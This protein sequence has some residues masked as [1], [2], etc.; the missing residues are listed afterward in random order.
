MRIKT[1]TTVTG[2][3]EIDFGNDDSQITAH[4]Y[5]FKNLSDS[6]LYVSSKPNPIAGEDNVAELSAKGAASVETDEGKVYVLG[7]GKVEIHRTNSKFCPFELPSNSSG[8]GGSSI[9]VDSELSETSINPVENKAIAGA[10][11]DI[12]AYIETITNDIHRI[13]NPNLLTNPD[14]RINQ[15]GLSTETL[16]TS[17]RYFIDRWKGQDGTISINNNGGINWMWDGT[18]GSYSKIAQD[19]ENLQ[20]LFGK[21]V[22]VSMDIDSVRKSHTFTLPTEL[23]KM[24]DLGK[25]TDNIRVWLGINSI[26]RLYFAILNMSATAVNINNLKLE[27]GSNATPFIPPEYSAELLKCQRYYQIHSTNNISAVDM[28]P[29]M[30]DS[31]NPTITALSNGNY[32]YSTEL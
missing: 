26:G 31:V 9:T 18:N 20:A 32:S 12:N 3:N 29:N 15:Y 22:T 21:I 23:N 8:G 1:I 13:S 4:F 10:I 2:I 6:T 17:L 5:W 28:R 27:V 19:F 30:C 7:A 14:F 24:T 11:N 25:L 16:G